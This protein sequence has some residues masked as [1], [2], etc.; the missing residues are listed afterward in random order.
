MDAGSNPASGNLSNS[1][2]E[3][4]M[5]RYSFSPRH[6]GLLA[7]LRASLEAAGRTCTV[8]VH[9]VARFELHTLVASERER[10]TTTIITAEGEH[11]GVQA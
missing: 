5:E 7:E 4:V 3:D 11:Y 2:Q 9:T 6:L 10:P 8:E 1:C